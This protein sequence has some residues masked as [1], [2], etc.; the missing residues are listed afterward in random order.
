MLIAYQ[1]DTWSR[2][3]VPRPEDASTDSVLGAAP[4]TGYSADASDLLVLGPQRLHLDESLMSLCAGHF[5]VIS[6]GDFCYLQKQLHQLLKL[7]TEVLRDE[8]GCAGDTER[9][10]G[11]S[12]EA[13]SHMPPPSLQGLPPS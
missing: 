11:S 12:P 2:N 13:S 9:D 10:L 7:S 4:P 1:T 5:L 3:Q 8:L 6:L